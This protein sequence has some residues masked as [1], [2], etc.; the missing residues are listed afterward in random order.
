MA[1]PAWDG[2]VVTCATRPDAHGGTGLAYLGTA[3]L[4]RGDLVGFFLADTFITLSQLQVWMRVEPLTGEYAIGICGWALIDT[5]GRSLVSRVNE[6]ARPNVEIVDINMDTGDDTPSFTVAAMIAIDTIAH[7]G[8]LHTD[9][10][11]GEEYERVRE[12]RGYTRPFDPD[13]P[14]DGVHGRI[15]WLMDSLSHRDLETLVRDALDPSQLLEVKTFGGVLD[16]EG[17]DAG[18][19]KDPNRSRGVLSGVECVAAAA[20]AKAA[21]A[22]ESV[23]AAAAAVVVPVATVVPTAVSPAV[24]DATPAA[25]A[26][27][28]FPV[29]TELPAAV[30]PVVDDAVH[31]DQW[32]SRGGASK[33]LSTRHTARPRAEAPAPA[34]PIDLSSYTRSDDLGAASS[35]EG[36]ADGDAGA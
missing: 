15:D 16:R 34:A 25:A 28:V 21:A 8:L 4:V 3:N 6:G 1:A 12:A 31:C 22:A 17:R 11:D 18:G 19:A 30:P 2:L 9:Y 10:G 35:C 33:R 14:P 24:V 20:A 32:R 7:G 26:A 5:A 23:A 27:A 36:V 29:A 13:S